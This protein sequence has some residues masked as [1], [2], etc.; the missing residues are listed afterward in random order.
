MEGF[1]KLKRSFFS[2][3]LWVEDVVFHKRE[4]FL[5]LLQLAAFAPTKRIVKGKLINVPVGGIVASERFLSERWK[6]SRTKVRRF[7]SLLEKDGMLEQK[8]DQGETLLILCN[9]KKHAGIESHIKTAKEPEEDQRKTSDEP[10]KKKDKKEKKD[11]SPRSPRVGCP[12]PSEL[13][14]MI[15]ESFNHVQRQ[16]AIDWAEDKQSRTQKAKRVQSLNSWA[17]ALNR[18]A[19]YPSEVLADAVDTA[20]ANGWQGWEQESVKEKMPSPKPRS[21]P[22]KLTEPEGWREVF[23]GM[24]PNGAVPLRW[25][26]VD[27]NHREE[28]LK[29]L[30]EQKSK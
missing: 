27:A 2:H 11:N 20:I 28:I 26:Y 18:M 25:S 6:W 23:R 12:S 3:W 19:L 1:F 4:S 24:F 22:K 16:A 21:H 5:D 29:I 10:N 30:N 8:K 15:P 13:I 14:E 7:L 17:K 9:Y